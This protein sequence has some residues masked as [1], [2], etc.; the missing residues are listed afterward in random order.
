MSNR[1]RADT[2]LGS[3]HGDDPTDR[4][5][6][7]SRE[8]PANR[9]HYIKRTDGRYQVI[10]YAP[11][12]QLAVKDDVVITPNDNDARTCITDLRKGIESRQEIAVATF[13]FNDDDIGRRRIAVRP[14]GGRESPHL[15]LDMGLGE[16]PV[17]S[18]GLNGGRGLDCFAK[19]LHGDARRRRDVLVG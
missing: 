5:G 13:R 19:S 2:A 15:Q 1:G 14:E 11:T 4:L 7:G 9:A 8:Q 17:L 12:Q 10:A 16:A 6:V 18:R 3:G